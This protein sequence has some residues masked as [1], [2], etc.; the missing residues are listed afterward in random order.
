MSSIVRVA[1]LRIPRFP[2]GAVWQAPTTS[3]GRG[4][5][6]GDRPREEGDRAW[7]E[8]PLALSHPS[9]PDRL[10]M[11]TRHAASLGVLNGMSVSAARAVCA[12]LDVRP[13]D[14]RIVR[15]SVHRVS[16]ELLSLSPQVTPERPGVWWIGANGLPAG[17][18]GRHPEADLVAALLALG[19]PWHPHA[20]AGVASSCVAAQAATW[21]RTPGHVVPPG[22]DGAFLRHAPLSLIPMDADL[23]ETLGALGLTVAGELAALDAGDVEQRFGPSGLTA[24]HLARGDDHRRAM[25]SRPA[26]DDTV[27]LDLPVPAD[28]LEPVLFLVRAALGRLLDLVRADA[29]AIARLEIECRLDAIPENGERRTENGTSVRG[30]P[31]QVVVAPARPLARLDPLYEQ[32]RASLED[33]V[34]EAP[35]VGIVVR[36]VERAAATGEQ[37][38]LLHTGWRDPAAADAAFARLR[39]ALGPGTVVRPVARDAF[40]PE[41]RGG[42]E[43]GG[44]NSSGGNVGG[45]TRGGRTSSG[46]GGIADAAPAAMP[47]AVFRLLHPAEAVTTDGNAF[48]W[49]GRTRPIV[50][51]HGA[52][53]LSGEWWKDPYAR[54]YCCW[55]SEGVVFL[56][57]RSEAS[58]F[59]QGWWD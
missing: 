38:D 30:L 32:C 8:L 45:G 23:R 16:A 9:H 47:P 39:A 56:S 6:T 15:Q 3:D 49:R 59:L 33:F 46:R 20:R 35:V 29:Q 13:W 44:G 25:L 54:D 40:A 2:I 55:E 43:V 58:W 52:E 1:C 18:S 10:I 51:R 37:G 26:P 31:A 41:R 50:Q 42:W 24:W 57:W 12:D 19:R 4:H 22:R 17:H 28:T 14:A 48:T 7:D 27:E 5:G 53:R 36:V 21:L 34:V 11:V